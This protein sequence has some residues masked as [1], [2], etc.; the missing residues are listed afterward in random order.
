MAD[1]LPQVQLGVLRVCVELGAELAH[2]L[3]NSCRATIEEAFQTPNIPT[4]LYATLLKVNRNCD[5]PD[6]W[7]LMFWNL[8]ISRPDYMN[9]WKTSVR[10][11]RVSEWP[12][13]GSRPGCAPAVSPW[14]EFSGARNICLDKLS[15][16]MHTEW[17]VAEYNGSVSTWKQTAT[18]RACTAR[19]GAHAGALAA[20]GIP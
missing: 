20:G 19:S 15:L 18:Q 16:M 8:A 17:Y 1:N 3:T 12:G 7:L 5:P 11:G 2:K 10:M 13:P 6:F 4:S 9:Y 14:K